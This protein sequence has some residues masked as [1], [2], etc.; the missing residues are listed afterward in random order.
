M[1]ASLVAAAG[2]LVLPEIKESSSVGSV[3]PLSACDSND[4]RLALEL[5]MLEMPDMELCRKQN[6]WTSKPFAHGSLEV[7]S[8]SGRHLL[9]QIWRVVPIG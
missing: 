6:S 3:K 9:Q 8:A 7:K 1:L 4:A 2:V 5:L